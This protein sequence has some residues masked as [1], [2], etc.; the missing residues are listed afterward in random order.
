MRWTAADDAAVTAAAAARSQ[1]GAGSAWP[2][3]D[4]PDRGTISG[5]NAKKRWNRIRHR[6][7]GA[8]NA[9]QTRS[10]PTAQRAAN[11]GVEF[12]P[13]P[14]E[15]QDVINDEDARASAVARAKHQLHKHQNAVLVKVRRAE[16]AEERAR[17]RQER[18]RALRSKEMEAWP[19]DCPGLAFEDSALLRLMSTSTSLPT[20][21]EH[22]REERWVQ[23][24]NWLNIRKHTWRQLR[25]RRRQRRREEQDRQD[26]LEFPKLTAEQTNSTTPEQMTRIWW[27]HETGANRCAAGREKCFCCV[28]VKFAV[29]VKKRELELVELDRDVKAGEPPGFARRMRTWSDMPMD[30]IRDRAKGRPYESDPTLADVVRDMLEAEARRPLWMK[31]VINE[32]SSRLEQASR[33]PSWEAAAI[34]EVRN[35]HDHVPPGYNPPLFR[36]DFHF[37]LRFLI[38]GIPTNQ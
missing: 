9:R 25:W 10:T 12:K 19:S 35:K 13:P 30:G 20:A 26:Q 32:A 27:G 16:A 18:A 17:L 24:K 28:C 2:A 7:A 11:A 23:F 8:P 37:K 15:F 21:E 36:D 33:A 6:S 14:S 22:A 3:V 1:P 29:D 31:Q 5:D 34:T 38:L 4:C